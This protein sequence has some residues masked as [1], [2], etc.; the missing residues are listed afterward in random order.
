MGGTDTVLAGVITNQL[1]GGSVVMDN[2]SWAENFT[3]TSTSSVEVHGN[4]NSNIIT[5]NSGN[6]SLDGGEGS[7]TLI[8]LAGRLGLETLSDADRIRK[9]AEILGV[10][11]EVVCIPAKAGL[12][13]YYP[14][15]SRSLRVEGAGEPRAEHDLVSNAKMVRLLGY[16]DVVGAD[17]AMRRTVKWYLENPL[18]PGGEDE[19]RLGDSFNY[20]AEDRL[21]AEYDAAL[22]RLDAAALGGG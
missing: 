15:V 6:D 7:D 17:E 2:I 3:W 19:E 21:L 11:V 16:R 12:P 8:G 9:I 20:A 4:A 1:A 18:P 22:R 13:G 10:P 14:G 5:G